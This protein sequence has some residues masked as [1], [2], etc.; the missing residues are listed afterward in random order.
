M[1]LDP[2]VDEIQMPSK[3]RIHWSPQLLRIAWTRS[4]LARR[5]HLCSLCILTVRATTK[6]RRSKMREA[7]RGLNC[8]AVLARTGR[9][10]SAL[11]DPGLSQ[12]IQSMLTLV[13]RAGPALPFCMSLILSSSRARR[14]CKSSRRA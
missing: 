5:T 6:P 4:R 12:S 7:R 8:Y 9:E 1:K 2:A 11:T 13:P 14:P 3:T 10:S